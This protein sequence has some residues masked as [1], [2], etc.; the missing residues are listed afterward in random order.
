MESL[1]YREG[2]P[3]RTYSTYKR[4]SPDSRVISDFDAGLYS[5]RRGESYS[6]K[7]CKIEDDVLDSGE[8][9]F[10]LFASLLDSARQ[11]ALSSHVN[12]IN[13][14][15]LVLPAKLIGSYEVYFVCCRAY[16]SA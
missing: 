11:G 5:L 4:R 7:A 1:D 9:T 13:E 10:S 3:S 16:I 14:V 12:C 15:V 6:L 8:T 2:T